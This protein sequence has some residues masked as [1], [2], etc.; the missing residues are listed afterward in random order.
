MVA[1]P[2][3][4]LTVSTALMERT[5]VGSTAKWEPIITVFDDWRVTAELVGEASFGEEGQQ[6]DLNAD[7]AIDVLP[8]FIG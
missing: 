7:V 2:L 4:V 8:P 3:G 6:A 1:R 5:V